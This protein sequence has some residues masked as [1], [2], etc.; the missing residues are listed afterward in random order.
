MSERESAAY[1]GSALLSQCIERADSDYAAKRSRDKKAERKANPPV[2][3]A[4]SITDA[5]NQCE[6]NRNR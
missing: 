2:K 4:T 3:C 5:A 6:K 1:W